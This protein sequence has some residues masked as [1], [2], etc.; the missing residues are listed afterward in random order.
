MM[1]VFFPVNR[2]KIE[3][4]DI[5]T[6]TGRRPTRGDIGLE[7]ECEGNKF[8][9]SNELLQ[10]FW[11]HH[12]DHSLR[13]KDNAEYVLAEPIDFDTVPTAVM[14][15]WDVFE[16]YGTKLDESNR[17]S[18]HAHLNVQRWNLNRLTSFCAIFFTLEEILSEWAGDHRV[19]NLFC[20]RAKDAPAIV[21]KLKKFIQFDGNF[22]LTDGLHYAGLNIQALQ[23]FGSLEIRYLRGATQPQLILDWVTILRRLYE[24]SAIYPDP[25]DV[26][27][28]FSYEGPLNFFNTILGP[29]ADIIHA[30]LPSWDR[31][32][33]SAS[34]YEGIRMAQDLVYCRDWDLYQPIV[35]R[36]DPFGRPTS[37]KKLVNSSLSTSP[38]PFNQFIQ[39]A[40]MAAQAWANGDSFDLP[41]MYSV[42]TNSS[43]SYTESGTTLPSLS[44]LNI[45]LSPASPY[46]EPDFGPDFPEPELEPEDEGEWDIHDMEEE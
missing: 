27:S 26:L 21:T 7:I 15:L 42:N 40:Q 39:S 46:E 6:L 43:V 19:G 32:T 4:Y 18:V 13:G 35:V 16:S 25:R 41:P 10:P 33:I 11:V 45:D 44:E 36:D 20:L 37:L 1:Q 29:T 5:K 28:L 12:V 38:G 17:T 23:K 34:L 3:G 22:E 14:F 8:L 30:G 24:Q 31:E 9:K 2:K